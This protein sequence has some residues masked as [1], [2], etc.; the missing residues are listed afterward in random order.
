MPL[1]ELGSNESSKSC[2]FPLEGFRLDL[3]AML[4]AKPYA[5]R[6]FHTIDIIIVLRK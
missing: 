6:I 5:L 2:L 4:A 3:P 1:R